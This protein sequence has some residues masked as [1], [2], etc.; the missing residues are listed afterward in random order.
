MKGNVHWK[1]Q[2]IIKLH[3]THI[4]M[5]FSSINWYKYIDKVQILNLEG[6]VFVCRWTGG[7]Q[8]KPIYHVTLYCFPVFLR[9]CTDFWYSVAKRTIISYTDE[10]NTQTR[11]VHVNMKEKNTFWKTVFSLENSDVSIYIFKS[12]LWEYIIILMCLPDFFPLF[13]IKKEAVIIVYKKMTLW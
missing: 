12:D 7:Q 10:V 1:C 13:G 8:L 6:R 3:R 2:S 5:L 9:C 4:L 11:V